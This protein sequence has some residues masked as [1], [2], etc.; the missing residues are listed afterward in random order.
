VSSHLGT[1]DMKCNAERPRVLRSARA[2]RAGRDEAG[3]MRGKRTQECE[4]SREYGRGRDY[5]GLKA[6][7]RRQGARPRRGSIDNAAQRQH[8]SEE[9]AGSRRG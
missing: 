6:R 5:A 4:A 7:L 1:T 8:A 9:K 2:R 3:P